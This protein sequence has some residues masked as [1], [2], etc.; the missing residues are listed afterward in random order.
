MCYVVMLKGLGKT[1]T[2]ERVFVDYDQAKRYAKHCNEDLIEAERGY[3]YVEKCLYSASQASQ[4][5]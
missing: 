2:S 4:P 1:V 3:F 5:E